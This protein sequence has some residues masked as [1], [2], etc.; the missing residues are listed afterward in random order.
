MKHFFPLLLWLA[1]LC[2]SAQSD[3][4]TIIARDTSGYVPAAMANGQLGLVVGREPF[5]VGPL[6]LGSA[7]ERGSRDRVS[8]ILEGI[9]PLGLS[10]QRIDPIRTWE[11]EIDMRQAVHTTR[12]TTDAVSVVYRIRALRNMP[13]AVM[14]EVEVEA[15]RDTEIRFVNRH[16]VPA[17]LADTLRENRTVWCEDGG[18]KVQRS[19]GSY[20]GG[21]DHVAATSVFL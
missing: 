7:C 20:N 16:A 8:R 1:P 13:Y 17:G 18:R 5:E 14:A 11:Q 6:L 2:V 3:G 15:L 12:F 9:C 21:A 4:W 19:E 10:M